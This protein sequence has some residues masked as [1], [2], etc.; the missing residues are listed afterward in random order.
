ML[1]SLVSSRLEP[2]LHVQLHGDESPAGEV[3]SALLLLQEER[4]F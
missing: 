1:W 2:Q 3:R 4:H